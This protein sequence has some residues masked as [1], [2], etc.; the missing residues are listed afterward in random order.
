[1]SAPNVL[2]TAG[3]TFGYL[4]DGGNEKGISVIQYT[5]KS[6]CVI[7]TQKKYSKEL[8]ELGGMFRN[9]W[10]CGAGYIFPLARLQT[11]KDF[12]ITGNVPQSMYAQQKAQMGQ[13]A[14]QAQQAPQ[15]LQSLAYPPPQAIQVPQ[16][17]VQQVLAPAE[18]KNE[19]LI[20]RLDHIDQCLALI[21]AKL[22]IAAPKRAQPQVPQAPQQF[23]Q[24]PQQVPQQVQQFVMPHNYQAPTFAYEGDDNAPDAPEDVQTDSDGR[25]PSL[26]HRKK[27]KA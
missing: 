2:S 12:I 17:R 8:L 21:M 1:M 5:P 23:L 16:V 18:E 25:M 10:K 27:P 9:N 24:T 26:A 20:Q 11:I 22:D 13:Q 14:P 7:D 3:G 6:V 4:V 15:Q 19:T